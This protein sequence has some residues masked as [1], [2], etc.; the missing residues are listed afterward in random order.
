MEVRFW[1]ILSKI[2]EEFRR[3]KAYQALPSSVP[4]A[5]PWSDWP[6]VARNHIPENFE[7][8]VFRKS[9]RESRDNFEI[10]KTCSSLTRQSDDMNVPPWFGWSLNVPGGLWIILVNLQIIII[11]FFIEIIKGAQ[12]SLSATCCFHSRHFTPLS[13]FSLGLHGYL[14]SSSSHVC[15]QLTD[16]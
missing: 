9:E 13:L 11:N 8:H 7:V 2:E 5:F 15:D 6:T 16:V 3:R 1:S 4:V 10:V 12:F 14:A